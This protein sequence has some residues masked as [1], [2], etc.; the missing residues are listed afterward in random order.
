MA[1]NLW[2]SVRKIINPPDI[3]VFA[4]LYIFHKP[5]LKFFHQITSNFRKKIYRIPVETKYTES[6]FGFIEK[7]IYVGL[8]FLPFVYSLDIISITLH[9]FG[10]DFHIKG[11]LSRLL[12]VVY[13]AIIAGMFIT[14]IKDFSLNLHRLKKFNQKLLFH[15]DKNSL[16]RRDQVREG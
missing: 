9:T 15:Q 2:P 10:F 8:M 1:A 7:P 14:K 3:A 11:D 16:M 5:L 13:E 4:I 12:C 6:L